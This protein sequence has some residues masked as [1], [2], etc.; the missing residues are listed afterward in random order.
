MGDCGVTGV[1]GDSAGGGVSLLCYPAARRREGWS[2]TASGRVKITEGLSVAGFGSIW[3]CIPTYML[4]KLDCSSQ[5]VGH[6]LIC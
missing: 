2:R 5:C 3:E 6:Q 1:G 4:G